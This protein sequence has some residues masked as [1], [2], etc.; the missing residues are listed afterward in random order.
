MFVSNEFEDGRTRLHQRFQPARSVLNLSGLKEQVV[1]ILLRQQSEH[2]ERIHSFVTIV[3][4]QR[5]QHVHKNEINRENVDGQFAS[6][7]IR[8]VRCVRTSQTSQTRRRA[9]FP[10]RAVYVIRV[11]IRVCYT[12]VYVR[13]GLFVFLKFPKFL[14]RSPYRPYPRRRVPRHTM[15]D[16][17][18]EGQRAL[19]AEAERYIRRVCDAFQLPYSDVHAEYVEDSSRAEQT[20]HSIYV[21]RAREWQNRDIYDQTRSESA[22]QT[23]RASTTPATSMNLH[24][25]SGPVRSSSH[26]ASN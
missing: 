5:S 8:R 1:C 3:P 25:P 22:S 17:D 19:T 4:S 12:R 18:E 13:S 16:L 21:H 9:R 10:Y 23:L 6:T 24:S 26:R 15:L 11:C 2:H 20:T 7:R 14:S